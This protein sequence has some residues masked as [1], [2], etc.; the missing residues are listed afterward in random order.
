MTKL[1]CV[2]EKIST[3][4]LLSLTA[5]ELK[6]YVLRRVDNLLKSK[7]VLVRR[8]LEYLLG[9]TGPGSLRIDPELVGGLTDEQLFTGSLI[10]HFPNDASKIA[11]KKT[12][13]QD[14]VAS[15]LRSPKTADLMSVLLGHYVESLEMRSAGPLVFS[16][17]SGRSPFKSWSTV[18][19][20]SCRIASFLIL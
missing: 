12:K 9:E 5:E 18:A 19:G 17:L 8:E 13:L 10:A 4:S 16:G 15:D 1:A 2:K 6:L 14:L 20:G 7:R 3:Q 11:G